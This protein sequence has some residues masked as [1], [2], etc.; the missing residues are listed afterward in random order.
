MNENVN[1]LKISNKI[2]CYNHIFACYKLLLNQ[3]PYDFNTKLFL[4]SK[5]TISDGFLNAL[6]RKSS[7]FERVGTNKTVGC[8]VPKFILI[9]NSAKR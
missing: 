6:K 5:I 3:I 9:K 4:N 1:L 7:I 2:V 8:D